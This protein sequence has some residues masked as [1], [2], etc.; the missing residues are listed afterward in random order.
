M[1]SDS[2]PSRSHARLS[3]ALACAFALA[4]VACEGG[5]AHPTAPRGSAALA[6]F[7]VI[8]GAF[9]MGV[10]SGGLVSRSQAAAW[11]AL[12]AADVGVAFQVP[13]MR[14]PGCSPPL[15]APLLLDR[16][17]SGSAATTRDTSCAGTI[18]TGVP[19][20]DNLAIAGATAWDAIH[21][22]PKAVATT[23]AAFDV[24]DRLRYP[25]VLGNTQ[26][27]VT[28]TLVKAPTLVAIE[29]GLG[30]VI[31]AA[32]TG[33][34]V[35]AS[36]Y[37]DQSGWTLAPADVFAPVFDAV[38]D[39]VAKTGAMVVI[40]SVPPVTR[41]P[42]FRAAA[43]VWASQAALA[44]FG[45]TVASDCATSQ[46]VL[47]VA[48]MV[49]AL[50]QAAITA[51]APQALSC[52][53][54]PAAADDVL[55]PADFASIDVAITGINAHLAQVAAARGWAYADLGG[56]FGGMTADAGDYAPHAQETCAAP[57]GSYFSLDGIHP[58]DS[59]QRRIADAVA[60]ALNTTYGFALRVVG[61]ALDTHVTPCP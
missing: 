47:D 36:A 1:A 26:S 39:S 5:D 6:H 31:R 24:V 30:E 17:L 56:V 34:V 48:A 33:R 59:G 18:T 44:S 54:V 4:L 50:A 38:A 15:V 49:P 61:S 13:L 9:A 12:L 37:D 57:Y 16:W 52:A 46:N 19:P 43:A 2:R 21:V 28:A 53:D 14:T 42:A 22:T 29:L 20:G 11:P 51:G 41:F 27:Q 7:A 32:V 45:I 35:A 58:N 55:T 10:Q 8:G 23:P 40:L 3:A 60:T 25:L